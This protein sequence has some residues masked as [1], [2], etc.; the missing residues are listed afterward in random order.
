[1][2][3]RRNSLLVGVLTLLWTVSAAVADHQESRVLR[4]PELQGQGKLLGGQ[5][6]SAGENG[7]Q[8]LR[9][10]NAGLAPMRCPIVTLDHLSPTSNN[11]AVEGQMQYEKVAG[12]AYLEMWTILPDGRRFFTRTLA[13]TGPLQKITGTSG[14]RS[15]SLPFSFLD[16][17]PKDVI[18]EISIFMP[19]AG[20]VNIGPLRIVNLSPDVFREHHAWWSNQTGGW[21]GGGL[22]TAIGMMM[23]LATVFSRRGVSRKPI[24]VIL[25]VIF[26]LGVICM[27]AGIVAV[28]ETQPFPV[29]YPLLLIGLMT[30]VATPIVYVGARRLLRQFELRKIQAMDT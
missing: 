2:N 29:Y 6:Q 4:W 15:F 20:T 5:V 10:G 3:M 28:I 9:I 7:W 12:D 30:M 22:G 26:A 16:Q 24:M 21:I 17:S 23:A 27:A 25:F 8:S 13:E 11:I 1:M 19:G 18:L 14:W